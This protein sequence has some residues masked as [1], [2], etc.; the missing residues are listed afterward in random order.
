LLVRSWRRGWFH[1]MENAD[2]RLDISL[3]GLGERRKEISKFLGTEGRL[4]GNGYFKG[5]HQKR[6]D[7]TNPFRVDLF[8]FSQKKFFCFVLF[9][10]LFFLFWFIY[11]E[12]R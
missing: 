5:R 3:F 11:T 4:Q 8:N 2:K 6:K 10:C 12:N 1:R 7:C 9:G